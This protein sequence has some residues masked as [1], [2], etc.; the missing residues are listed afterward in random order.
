MFKIFIVL[1]FKYLH[2]KFNKNFLYYK[3]VDILFLTF[4]INS[5]YYSLNF[6][7]LYK[8]SIV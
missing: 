8:N 2:T 1:I 7:K 3:H 6:I 4:I 5:L